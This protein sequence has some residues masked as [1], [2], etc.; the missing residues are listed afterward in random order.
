MVGVVRIDRPGAAMR[1]RVMKRDRFQCTYCGT[2]GTDAELEV[3]HI[4]PVAGGGSNHM[5]NLTTACRKCNQKKSDRPAKEFSMSRVDDAKQR[6][7][8]G[9]VGMF[10]WILDPEC[11]ELR[12]GEPQNQ[13]HIIACEDGMAFVELFSW[14]DGSTTQVQAFPKSLLL[15]PQKAT[16]FSSNQR[17]LDE[18]DDRFGYRNKDFG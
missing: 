6:P 18:Y 14:L 17:M 1:I 16:L 4:I 2:P 13:G 7:A 10:V 12:R 5:S 9:F 15:D 8:R 11:K 3:D